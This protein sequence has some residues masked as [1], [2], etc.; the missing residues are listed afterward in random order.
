MCILI[1]LSICYVRSVLS[2]HLLYFI[3]ISYSSYIF[4]YFVK[5]VFNI[6]MTVNYVLFISFL[7]S[8]TIL[9]HT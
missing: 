5:Y 8:V 4:L 2:I 6:A 7:L 9:I 3:C 1:T